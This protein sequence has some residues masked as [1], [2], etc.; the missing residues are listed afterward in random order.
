MMRSSALLPV[1][2]SQS[3][4]VDDA[5]PGISE[6][7]NASAASELFADR[8]RTRDDHPLRATATRLHDVRYEPGRRCYAAWELEMRSERGPVRHTI[9]VVDVGSGAVHVR[10]FWEDPDLPTLAAAVTPTRVTHHL[11]P[12]APA[13]IVERV[14]PVRYRL[15]S[16]CTLRYDFS[17]SAEPRSLFGKVLIND[18][19]R[20]LDAARAIRGSTTE[21]HR[22]P[23][24]EPLGW[25]EPLRMLLLSPCWGATEFHD[26]VFDTAVPMDRRRALMYEAG[27]TLARLHAAPVSDLASRGIGTDVAAV[28]AAGD[29]VA[30]CAPE[31]WPALDAALERLASMPSAEQ[32]PVVSHGAFRTDQLLALDTDT[33]MVDLDGLCLA[34]PARDLGNFLAYL[35]WKAI[36][37]P[38]LAPFIVDAANSFLDGY[39]RVARLPDVSHIDVYEAA[40]MLK[41]ATR[42]FSRLDVGEWP[43]VPRLIEEA[44]ELLGS[45]GPTR[46][47][48]H[49]VEHV[50]TS[51]NST[52]L[53]EALDPDAMNSRLAPLLADGESS[54]SEPNDILEGESAISTA[55]V[56]TH[57]SGRRMT[58]QYAQDDG[59]PTLMGKLYADPTSGRRTHETMRLLWD[60]RRAGSPDLGMPQPLGWLPDLKM[61][62]Y[63]PVGGR[64]LG[65]LLLRCRRGSPALG[66]LDRTADWLGELHRSHVLLDRTFD[67]ER[68]LIN[69]RGWASSIAERHPEFASIGSGIIT[70]LQG[71]ASDLVVRSPV[72]IHKDF[73]HDHVFVDDDIRVIDF[74]E[75]RLGDPAFDLGHFCAYLRVLG[76]PLGIDRSRV[77]LLQDRFLDAYRRATGWTWD[78]RLPT[79]IAYGCLKIARQLDVRSRH[80][81][82]AGKEIAHR[83]VGAMLREAATILGPAGGAA[84]S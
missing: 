17:G 8:W 11:S 57:R 82:G 49:A 80:A 24:V 23:I 2:G 84:L 26:I 45:P 6:A 51:G 4:F 79:F 1:A 73:H 27:S 19:G 38:L 40:S 59:A 28:R 30:T 15:G 46:F 32:A 33:V 20:L 3:A 37:Q 68:E 62:V 56:L 41:I 53:A 58:I 67:P 69:I 42:R 12:F 81:R 64:T 43:L 21:E 13:S 83:K 66:A 9:G 71:R 50:G 72:P 60:R 39:G 31:T 75:V 61:L 36:R 22:S 76:D 35:R 54:E 5:L 63:M 70:R 29:A 52:A 78:D 25:C 34:D 18:A 10:G 77:T 7:L 47:E 65:E 44:G 74:D 14:D 48:T 55:E 16:R